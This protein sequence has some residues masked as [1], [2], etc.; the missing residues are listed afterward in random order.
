MEQQGNEQREWQDGMRMQKEECW[1]MCEWGSKGPRDCF[2]SFFKSK[3]ASLTI[4]ALFT[5]L[6]EFRA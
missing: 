3:Q 1:E 4:F 6:L 2:K 5:F